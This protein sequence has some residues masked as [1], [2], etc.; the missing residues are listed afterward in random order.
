MESQTVFQAEIQ[1]KKF[2]LNRHPGTAEGAVAEQL[3]PDLR[4]DVLRGRH[5]EPGPRP[6]PFHHL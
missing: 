6:R 4:V 1:A 5:G 2:L 3:L